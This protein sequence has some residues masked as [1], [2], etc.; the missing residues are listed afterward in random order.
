MSDS[1]EVQPGETAGSA[2]AAKTET[3]KVTLPTYDGSSDPKVWLR[4]L[5]KIRK[6]KKWSK[7]H[8][9]T[10]AP[11]LL[12]GRADDFWETIESDVGEDWERFKQKIEDEFGEKKTEGEHLTD[13]TKLIREVDEPLPLLLWRMEKKFKK[14][15]PSAGL[16][17]S[18][19]VLSERF[20]TA[21]AEGKNKGDRELGQHLKVHQA[22]EGDPKK[23][24]KVAESLEKIMGRPSSVSSVATIDTDNIEDRIAQQVIKSLSD[25]HLDHQ[26]GVQ[27]VTRGARRQPRSQGRNA[28]RVGNQSDRDSNTCFLCHQPGHFRK[29]CPHRDS[30]FRCWKKG[31]S[32]RD[33]KAP[34]PVPLNAQWLGAAGHH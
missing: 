14:A 31:H 8:M 19:K 25:I 32:A 16:D 34:T 11:L 10:Q 6:A 17:L 12:V 27:A 22:D 15:F 2:V 24:L 29:N 9:V 33:C 4:S 26:P 21:L 23:L 28:G 20:T 18:N 7:E 30:C 5:E 1:E 13:L 3:L